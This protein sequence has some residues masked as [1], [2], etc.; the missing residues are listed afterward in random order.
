M[1]YCYAASKGRKVKCR[2]CGKVF[3]TYH[4]SQKTCS[5]ECSMQNKLDYKKELVKIHRRYY[6]TGNVK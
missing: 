1:A 2:I 6:K 5:V 4:P 3:T